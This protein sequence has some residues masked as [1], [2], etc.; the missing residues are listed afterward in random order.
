MSIITFFPC[1]LLQLNHQSWNSQRLF[2]NGLFKRAFLGLLRNSR[3][4]CF[5]LIVNIQVKAALRALR[6]VQN[7][8]ILRPLDEGHRSVNDILEW[9]SSVFGF[10]V[11]VLAFV[12]NYDP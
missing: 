11:T 7:L 8:P 10:Q 3:P 4:L 2:Y 1:T 5:L 12:A 9:L 6:D